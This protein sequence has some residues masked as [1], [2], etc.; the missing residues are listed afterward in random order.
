MFNEELTFKKFG[1]YIKDLL[2]KSQKRIIVNCDKCNSIR[3]VTKADYR[4]LC[5]SCS[6]KGKHHSEEAK[7]KISETRKGK[8]YI[9]LSEAKRGKLKS[10]ETKQKMKKNSFWRDKK[11]I[12]SLEHRN[13]LKE[14]HADFSGKNHPGYKGGITPLRTSIYNLPEYFIWQ[15]SVFKRDKHTCRECGS[16]EKIEA[17]HI[18]EFSKI[19]AEFLIE[20]FYFNPIENK[21]QLLILAKTYQPFWVISNGKTL[22]YNCHCK[23]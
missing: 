4:P 21:E 16:K 19:F 5:K 17:H 8:H 1:Y 20:Y 14:N 11:R 7:Q 13:N 18:R 2:L 9:K 6:L 10:E 3:E 23:I 22:C 12:F 15:V